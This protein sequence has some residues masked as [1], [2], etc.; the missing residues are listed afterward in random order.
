MKIAKTSNSRV[1]LIDGG[2]RVDHAPV[3]Q[4]CMKSGGLT[5]GQG[6]TTK[7]ECPSPSK[8]GK[9][10]TV[11][12][13]KAASDQPSTTLT[14]HYSL[15]TLSKLLELANRGCDFDVQLHFGV[16]QSPSVF[17]T[18]D[19]T[20]IIEGV[21]ITNWSTEDVGALGQ[22]EEAKVD[23]SADVSGDKV[24]EVVPLSFSSRDPVVVTNELI[25]VVVCDS[26]TCGSECSADS[27]G[28]QKIYALSLAAGGSAGTPA[29]CV[30]SINGGVTWYAHDV[31]TV[32][33]AQAVNGIACLGDYVV[34]VSSGANSL[35]YVSKN[36][37]NA[38]TDPAWTAV[39]TGF[40]A[41][42][43]PNDIW[44]TGTRAWIVANG[45]Y[46][47]KTDD[48]TT[49]V[50]VQ[51]AG[52]LTTDNF[53]AVHAY[54][55]NIAVAVGNNGAIAKTIDGGTTWALVTPAPTGVGTHY[56]TVWVKGEKEWII[57]TS[58]GKLYYTVDGGTT[59][60][61]KSFSGSGSGKVWNL[62]FPTKSVGYMSHATSANRG[63]LFQTIDGGYSWF[64]T[65][66][67]TGTLPL[68]DR[69]TAL[70]SCG[71]NP[72]FVVG[73]GLADNGTDGFVLT[74][75]APSA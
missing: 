24:Y 2:A 72:N 46:I 68:N 7:I 56:T 62:S 31:D 34:V 15:N 47:Y 25:D 54:D 16:C 30:F 67:G 8:Y 4:A 9:Y 17:N 71:D 11:G 60:A 13:I 3:Y 28:C 10:D 36:D 70:A 32:S 35:S 14:N 61:E 38:T 50:T 65:P 29:D 20:T 39:T 19:K 64:I 52:T 75:A 27:I 74:G 23:E 63:R 41:T 69:L 66:Q 49:A 53:L 6:D 18:Y 33:T 44:S 5:W 40:V 45:G 12:E 21:S 51:S 59:F 48:A 43:T 1:F 22:D 42:K 26:V 58:G 57:G 37:L 55:D 73:V